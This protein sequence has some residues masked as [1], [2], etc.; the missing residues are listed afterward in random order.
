MWQKNTSAVFH[1]SK[2]KL[3]SPPFSWNNWRVACLFAAVHAV[4]AAPIL[5]HLSS[6]SF[7][8]G[9]VQNLRNDLMRAMPES[10]LDKR[11]GLFSPKA[12]RRSHF[13]RLHNH[14]PVE[15]VISHQTS[16]YHRL[17]NSKIPFLIWWWHRTC[18]PLS[19]WH[20]W[21]AEEV[22]TEVMAGPGSLQLVWKQ[23]A[24][25]LLTV[26][27]MKCEAPGWV[28]RSI[29][30]SLSRSLSRHNKLHWGRIDWFVGIPGFTFYN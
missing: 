17:G 18:W 24:L 29:L 21:G 3:K 2:C 1:V 16:L 6:L 9:T 19:A 11:K 14:R 8:P 28:C 13:C 27:H 26:S 23:F 10:R 22:N 4:W 12:F 7:K 20:T 30:T 5:C 15:L 25:S